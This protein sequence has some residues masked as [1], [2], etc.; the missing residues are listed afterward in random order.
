MRKNKKMKKFIIFSKFL[1]KLVCLFTSRHS[2]HLSWT[3]HLPTL[4]SSLF[5][6]Q[7]AYNCSLV[8]GMQERRVTFTKIRSSTALMNLQRVGKVAKI[9]INKVPGLCSRRLFV[10]I[11]MLSICARTCASI[12]ASI[13]AE[14]ITHKGFSIN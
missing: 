2:H 9:F 5:L 3:Y 11:Y 6:P 4:S 13:L 12:C 10:L 8:F 1:K 7:P 14:S